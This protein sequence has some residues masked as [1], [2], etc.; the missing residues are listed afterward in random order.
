[1]QDNPL[2][3]GQIELYPTM[4]WGQLTSALSDCVAWFFRQLDQGLRT[5]KV[6]RL[7]PEPTSD[8]GQ[9]TLG[10]TP[11]SVMGYRLGKQFLFR[12][13]HDSWNNLS[14]KCYLYWSETN[15][16][17]GSIAVTLSYL[18]IIATKNLNKQILTKFCRISCFKQFY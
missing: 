8:D 16:R 3:I 17:M 2:V 1:M 11:E 10:F 14:V 9:Y 13:V 18:K 5:K 7:D 6:T 15:S 12:G 4:H